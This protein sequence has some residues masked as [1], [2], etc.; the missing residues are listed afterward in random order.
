[1]KNNKIVQNDIYVMFYMTAYV[2]LFVY[3][4][5]QNLLK[6]KVSRK[7]PTKNTVTYLNKKIIILTHVNCDSEDKQ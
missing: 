6:P 7:L 4:C 2:C 1:M 3:F 5:I